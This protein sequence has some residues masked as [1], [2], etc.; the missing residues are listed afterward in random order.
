PAAGGGTAHAH[1][2]GGHGMPGFAPGHAPAGLYNPGNIPSLLAGAGGSVVGADQGLRCQF[3]ALLCPPALQA[4]GIPPEAD[5]YHQALGALGISGTGSDYTA[6]YIA[7][8]LIPGAG[9]EAAA[10]EGS[11]LADRPPVV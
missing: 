8:A 5:P 11:R 4:R 2:M 9:E 10:G 3:M 1:G 7:L 6:G